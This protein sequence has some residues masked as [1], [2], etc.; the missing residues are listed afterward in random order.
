MSGNTE[1]GIALATEVL[2]VQLGEREVLHQL[3]L[4]IPKG[5]WTAI[6]G[7]NG[8]GKSTLLRVLAGLLPAASGQVLLHGR[9]QL[10]PRYKFIGG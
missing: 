9:D 6:V 2:S 3:S 4:Q 1:T 8:A 10:E 5:R 7:P